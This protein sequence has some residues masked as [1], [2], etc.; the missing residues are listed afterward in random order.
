MLRKG[1]GSTVDQEGYGTAFMATG[2]EGEEGGDISLVKSVIQYAER[3]V[4]A[5]AKLS[6]MESRL[7]QLEMAPPTETAYFTPQQPTVAPNQQPP[8]YI[9]VPSQQQT[10]RNLAHCNR[11]RPKTFQVLL[12]NTRLY[13]R[14][15]I[16]LEICGSTTESGQ[17]GG[18]RGNK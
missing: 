11:G 16:R 10:F 15:Q 6:A 1:G 4:V 17:S 12:H 14:W 5:E 13:P 3:T 2:Q 9:N 7:S 8:A 18:D